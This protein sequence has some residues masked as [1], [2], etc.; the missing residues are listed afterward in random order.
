MREFNA[1]NGQ[2]FCAK[3]MTAGPRKCKSKWEFSIAITENVTKNEPKWNWFACGANCYPLAPVFNYNRL[4]WTRYA[5]NCKTAIALP[6]PYKRLLQ[7]INEYNK[8]VCC[9]WT[10]TS[11]WHKTRIST[12]IRSVSCHSLSFRL[13]LQF[14]LRR[15]VEALCILNQYCV[16]TSRFSTKGLCHLYAYKKMMKAHE[17][18]SME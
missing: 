17:R 11:K 9:I 18:R 5:K 10:L 16:K 14:P 4:Q 8:C 15:S 13:I 12:S 2:S 6:K 3:Q 1:Q 7:D